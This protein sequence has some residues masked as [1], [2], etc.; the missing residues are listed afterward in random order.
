MGHIRGIFVRIFWSPLI[1]SQHHTFD[2][3][4][5]AQLQ[6]A[7]HL[8]FAEEAGGTMSG[9]RENIKAPWVTDKFITGEPYIALFCNEAGQ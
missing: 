3:R 4:N 7:L 2:I 6:K 1:F 9:V 8:L 5:I